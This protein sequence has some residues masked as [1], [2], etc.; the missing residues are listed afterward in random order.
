MLGGDLNSSDPLAR[1]RVPI[2]PSRS[3]VVTM[4]IS[5]SLDR[6]ELH[7]HANLNQVQRPGD[8]VSDAVFRTVRD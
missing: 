1:V 7:S 4:A 5:E 6:T 3:E 8:I 2:V